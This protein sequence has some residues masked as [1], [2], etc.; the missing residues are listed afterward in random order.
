[1]SFA[2]VFLV[3][4]TL[5]LACVV[6]GNVC[7]SH[8]ARS[9][10][11]G[12]YKRRLITGPLSYAWGPINIPTAGAQAFNMDGIGKLGHDPPRGPS[13]D[14]RMLTTADAAGTNGL[15]CLPK[16]G[17]TR[18]RRFLVTHSLTGHCESCLTS[19]IAAERA[20][21][22]RHRAPHTKEVYTAKS[23]MEYCSHFGMAKP[24]T[25]LLHWTRWNDRLQSRRTKSESGSN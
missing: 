7:K 24:N 19:T 13:A 15:T 22:L 11:Y 18:D 2:S 8:G 16:R 9:G 12:G 25:N 4:V 3:S 5:C 10:L 6:L 23:Y 17:G 1:M 20:N 21:N 14:W